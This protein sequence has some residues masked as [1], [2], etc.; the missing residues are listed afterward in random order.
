M[1]AGVAWALLGEWMYSATPMALQ[2]VIQLINGNAGLTIR[3]A[4][5][6]GLHE[7]PPLNTSTSESA[8]RYEV[9][10]VRHYQAPERTRKSSLVNTCSRFSR[11]RIIWQDSLLSISY[12]RATSTVSLTHR[13]ESP[14][15]SLG[16]LTYNDCMLQLCIIAT[17]VVNGRMARMTTQQEAARI[18]ERQ[19]Q[20]AAIDGRAASH[21]REQL[22]CASMKDHLEHC[23]WR[24]HRAY[25][26]SEICRP[27]L[28]RRGGSEVVTRLRA[29]CI[30]ALADTVEAFLSLHNWTVFASN[31]W[32][33][34]HRSL[35]SAL[36][37]GVLREPGR[38]ERAR[39]LLDRLVA[40][41]A[42][43]NTAAALPAPLTR[44]VAALQELNVGAAQGTTPSESSMGEGASPHAQVH[45]ILW[46]TS[47]GGLQSAGF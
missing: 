6:M 34:V 3:L 29:A 40:V 30:D 22:A 44:A 1:N 19:R 5:G 18:E 17:G 46:G 7:P 28:A 27:M 21:L 10:Y 35:G 14:S 41:M 11:S 13:E 43:M 2:S 23:N 31:S 37:L 24:M 42:T 9:W 16:S 45:R 39:T 15:S 36:L 20:V 33:A 26:V 12:D 38:S 4:Q 32:A 8:L 25:V 47:L